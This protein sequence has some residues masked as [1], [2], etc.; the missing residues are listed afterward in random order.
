LQQ[1]AVCFPA[2]FPALSPWQCTSGGSTPTLTKIR[3]TRWPAAPLWR[4]RRCGGLRLPALRRR[5]DPRGSVRGEIRPCGA[6]TVGSDDDDDEMARHCANE[7]CVLHCIAGTFWFFFCKPRTMSAR[8]SGA[9]AEVIAKLPP[10]STNPYDNLLD[11]PYKD[12]PGP[13]PDTDEGWLSYP[14]P[15]HAPFPLEKLHPHPR[16]EGI[17]F[18]EEEHVYWLWNDE[19]TK[20]EQSQGSIS[21]LAADY[22]EEFDQDAVAKRMA[23]SPGFPFAKPQHTKYIKDNGKGMTEQEILASWERNGTIQSNKGTKMHFDAELALNGLVYDQKSPEM[24]LFRRWYSEWFRPKGL[25]P[26]RSE[27]EIYHR[28]LGLAGTIDF[29][30]YYLNEEGEAFVRAEV[31]RRGVRGVRPT[32]AEGRPSIASSIRKDVCAALQKVLPGL[33]VGRYGNVVIIDWKRSKHVYLE[34]AEL[35]EE[36][37]MKE[38]GIPIPPK[39]PW[40]M[41]KGKGPCSDLLDTHLNKYAIQVNSYAWVLKHAYGYTVKEL[42]LVSFHSDWEHYVVYECPWMESRIVELLQPRI[43]DARVGESFADPCTAPIPGREPSRDGAVAA[44]P[45]VVVAA[46]DAVIP[47]EG[48]GAFVSSSSLSPTEASRSKPKKRVREEDLELP[49]EEDAAKLHPHPKKKRRRRLRR[50]SEAKGAGGSRRAR[51][52]PPPS[53]AWPAGQGSL[54]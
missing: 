29:V 17:I 34:H 22:F 19:S 50:R 51:T 14:L 12:F 47:A 42:Y 40:Q 46:D 7:V 52:P 31:I 53:L 21:S 26:L 32:R 54:H 37:H 9:T 33:D 49:E 3:C 24:D 27:W 48:G 28:R 38:K 43:R 23:K 2:C 5:K 11:R 25:I 8:F 41:R 36:N 6:G 30:G 16:D 35:E 18:W 15:G 39:K 13:S 45:V 10:L 44:K 20:W 4:E 1:P